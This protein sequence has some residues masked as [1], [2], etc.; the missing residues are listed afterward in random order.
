MIP[1]RAGSASRFIKWPAVAVVAVASSFFTLDCTK[2]WW[3]NFSDRF[4]MT[5][6][7]LDSSEY[8][9]ESKAKLWWKRM[10]NNYRKEEDPSLPTDLLSKIIMENEFTK[11]VQKGAIAK[12]ETN[13]IAANFP[14]EDR[15]IECFFPNSETFFFGV[16]DGHSGYHCSQTVKDRLPHYVSLALSKIRNK[17][18][19]NNRST[20][21]TPEVL[22][23]T[24][25]DYPSV[26]LPED[27]EKKQTLLGT[28]L[29]AFSKVLLSD[30]NSPTTNEELIKLAFQILDKDICTEAIPEKFAD[31]SLMTGLTGSCAIASCI[32]GDD[33]FIANTGD[34]R[35]VIGKRSSSGR[36]MASQI[37]QD[38]TVENISE[39]QRI[40][41]DHP[42]ENRAIQN[43]RLLGQLQPLRSFGDVQY[44]WSRELHGRVLNVVYGRPVVPLHSY[45]TPPYLTAEPVVSHRRLTNEDK[46]LI[47]ASDGLW[48]KMTS[49]QAV[50]IIGC[51][52]DASEQ[53]VTQKENG[54]TKLIRYALGKGND[55]NLANML[56]LPQNLKRHHH[57]DITVTVVYF[58]GNRINSKL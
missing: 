58:T 33:L 35:A 17:P 48:E 40:K 18:M 19:G 44:K 36:W 50:A 5:L 47:I 13:Q 41:S 10:M 34:C 29:R 46:F 23:K 55:A 20:Q 1:G 6:N 32:Q 21:Q 8:D 24:D 52:M 53:G 28:G 31:E 14:I 45:L 11:N 2:N 27:F 15:N 56:S 37:T 9:N 38:Q 4:G 42:N 49:E 43:G 3:N 25:F 22:G 39:V 57:D 30:A 26:S 16:F 51:A 12:F 54:A 7:A